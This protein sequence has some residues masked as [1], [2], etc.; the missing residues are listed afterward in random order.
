[1]SPNSEI[2]NPHD[3]YFR[4]QFSRIEVARSFFREYLPSELAQ[5]IDWKT[6]RL[7]PGDFVQKA[8]HNRKTD[9]LYQTRIDDREGY[10]YLHF[11]HQRSVDPQMAFRLL[12]Y[13]VNIWE[14]H[15]K[16]HPEEKTIPLIVPMVLYQGE[17]NWSAPLD[18]HDLLKV[19]GYLKPYLPGFSY[20]LMDLSSYSDEQIKGEL[21]VQLALQV[22]KHVD[23]PDL[24]LTL[25]QKLFPFV[26]ELFGTKTGLEA[27]KTMLYYLSN[28]SDHL[29]KDRVIRLFTEAPLDKMGAEVIMTLAEQWRQEGEEKG[30]EKGKIGIVSRQLTIRF[31]DDAEQWLERLKELSADELDIVSERLLTA[32][33]IADVFSGLGN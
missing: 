22:M 26:V 17:R 6:F 30:I 21:F 24:M 7:A 20:L 11:E 1:M 3:R 9:I 31:R 32:G 27:I 16:Q 25:E 12:I 19:P 2:S 23:S 8:L 5:A 13:M 4:E 15:Q 18:L 14:Q 10:C 33:S 28:S 29:D